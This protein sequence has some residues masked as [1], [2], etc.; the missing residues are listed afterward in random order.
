ME[1][2]RVLK[3]EQIREYHG[4]YYVP[5]NLCLLVCGKLAS[6]TSSLL[7]V[8]QEQIEPTLVSH[9]Q[10]KGPR[11]P[12]WK[13][14]FLETETAH[15]QAITETIK[16]TVEF[17][18]KDES[19]GELIIS[20]LG[21][22]TSAFLERKALDIV[23]TYLTSSAVAPLNKEYI[24]VDNPLCTYIYFGEDARATCVDLPIYVGSIPTEHLDSFDE[25]LKASLERVVSEGI[26]MQRMAMVI[27]RDERQLRSKLESAKGDTFSEMVIADFLYGKQ[28]GS[29]LPAS[30][31]EINMY[32]ELRKWSSKQWADL[33]RK[34]YIDPPRVVVRGKP[35]PSLAD[36]IEK[37]EKA[38]LEKQVKLLGPE[39]IAAA[40]KELEAAKEEHDR[41][42]PQSVLK[43]FPVPSVKSISWIPVQ[44]V[45]QPGKGRT[46]KTP[47]AKPAHELQKHV[48]ND[49]SDLPFFVQYDDVKSDFVTVHALL[50]LADLP[51]ELRPYMST[52][53]S[54]FFALPVKRE[55]GEKLTHEEVVNKLD[56]ETVSY[57]AT[58]GFNGIFNDMFRASIK[59]ET[60]RYETAIVWLKDLLY[61]SEFTKD[62]LQVTVAKI[63]QT[64]P[65]LNVMVAMSSAP[66]ALNS[67]MIKVLLL[68]L[69]LYLIRWNSFRGLRSNFRKSLKRLLPTLKR[70][71]SLL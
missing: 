5:H 38:R 49:G 22:A 4:T 44:S 10:N 64:I 40:V 35:S 51:N 31:D 7:K 50:S 27:N 58:L 13:R 62:R 18:E 45:Q 68:L 57:E 52:Y 14:P 16:K 47:E 42:I 20:F 69:V 43:S 32:A 67:S 66:L 60:P 21:P 12:G 26:D 41:P 30:M 8:I 70:F 17:P 54:A 48:E 55:S 59:V 6:G 56:D 29:E 19:V 3:V 11:P 1:A 34:Y 15:R 61:G 23:G 39:G 33:L 53:L 2:L 63:Q 71:V 46:V 24:E 65:E 9:G 37:D 28:D 36:R 25:K